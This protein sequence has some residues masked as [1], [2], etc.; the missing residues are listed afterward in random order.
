[1][2]FTPCQMKYKISR[3][4]SELKNLLK[5]ETRLGE[6]NNV[7]VIKKLIKHLELKNESINK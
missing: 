4:L 2:A 1:M 6:P 7:K 5:V 3:D